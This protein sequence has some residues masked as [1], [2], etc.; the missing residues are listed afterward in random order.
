MDLT[1][2]FTCCSDRAPG[3]LALARAR[4]TRSGSPLRL[5]GRLPRSRLGVPARP[6]PLRSAT[7]IRFSLNGAIEANLIWTIARDKCPNLGAVSSYE[8]KRPRNVDRP[9]SPLQPRVGDGLGLLSWGR[10]DERPGLP[11]PGDESAPEKRV[12]PQRIRRVGA[13]GCGLSFGA[14]SGQRGCCSRRGG[15][16]L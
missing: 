4:A 15:T 12:E 5:A 6:G 16:S 8:P 13:E 2:N 7:Y 11:V 14:F 10:A 3:L 1:E 9:L